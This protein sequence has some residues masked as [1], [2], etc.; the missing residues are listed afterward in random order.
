MHEHEQRPHEHQSDVVRH[1]HAFG[2]Y[3]Y[4]RPH[5]EYEEDGFELL[6]HDAECRT[7]LPERAM[8]CAR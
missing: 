6:L 4:G 8:L 7:R 1:G 2:C 3:R 5:R